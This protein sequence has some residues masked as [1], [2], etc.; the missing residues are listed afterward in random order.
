MTADPMHKMAG[1]RNVVVHGYLASTSR[2]SADVVANRLG[3]LVDFVAAIRS[4][5]KSGED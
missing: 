1:F 5:L 4:R 3:D 2:F